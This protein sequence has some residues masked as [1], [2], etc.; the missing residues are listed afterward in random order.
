MK[1]VSECDSTGSRS[2]RRRSKGAGL[3]VGPRGRDRVLNVDRPSPGLADLTLE[4][5]KLQP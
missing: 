3:G 1:R 5:R 4:S 2:G